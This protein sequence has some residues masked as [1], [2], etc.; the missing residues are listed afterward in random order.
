MGLR[1][2]KL[3]KLL[4]DVGDEEGVLEE[5]DVQVHGAVQEG[6]VGVVRHLGGVVHPDQL[7]LELE[8]APHL[9]GEVAEEGH[10]HVQARAVPEAP[11][12]KMCTSQR[13]VEKHEESIVP[14]L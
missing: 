7:V 13:L 11:G 10:A 6:P 14:L 9:R 5:P 4:T 12:E 1:L 2:P 8:W 3:P